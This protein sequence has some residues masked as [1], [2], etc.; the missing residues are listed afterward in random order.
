MGPG[1]RGVDIEEASN[2]LRRN[3]GKIK[4]DWMVVEVEG[5]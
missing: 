1:V 2:V 5:F 3:R 4:A